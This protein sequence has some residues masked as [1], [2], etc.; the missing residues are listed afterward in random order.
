MLP[1]PIQKLMGREFLCWDAFRMVRLLDIIHFEFKTN[2][3]VSFQFLQQ[4]E[5]HHIESDRFRALMYLNLMSARKYLEKRRM[6]FSGKRKV[7]QL[8]HF[9]LGKISIKYVRDFGS[10]ANPEGRLYQSKMRLYRKVIPDY[11]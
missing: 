2:W 10:F 5:R 7:Y 4:L 3:F 11:L 1:Q 6:P 9:R 8:L